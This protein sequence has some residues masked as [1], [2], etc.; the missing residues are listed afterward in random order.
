MIA[1]KEHIREAERIN[2]LYEYA[3]LDT[4]Q[5]EDFDQITQ[6]ASI[7]CD[8]PIN[9]ISLVDKNRQWFKSKIGLEV[10]ETPR[11]YSFCGH[12]IHRENEV[13]EI[14]DALND[15]R[16][17]DNPLVTEEPNI[18]FYAGVPLVSEDGLP[19][20]TVCVIDRKPKKLTST[21]IEG[22]KA[23]SKQLMKLLE[24]RIA[25]RELEHSLS[26]LRD[27]NYQL[28][29]FASLAAHDIKSP[30]N[31]II[32]AAHLLKLEYRDKIDQGGLDILKIVEDSARK[33]TDMVTGILE[34]SKSDKV[35]WE[36][37]STFG[38]N[39]LF[40]DVRTLV[41]DDKHGRISFKHQN[42]TIT[43]NRQAM[44]QI[45]LN[46]VS[47]AIKYNDKKI[48]EIHLSYQSANR[49][50]VFHITDNGPGIPQ[51]RIE[52]LFNLFETGGLKD[53][54]GEHGTGIGLA[55]VKK[56]VD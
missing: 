37:V 31:N 5:E 15:S 41:F 25:H 26:I 8:T 48:P 42:E 13:F 33:M 36:S 24:L 1:P 43:A 17:E 16:F 47:N 3:I 53:R 54:F 23:L 28:E 12:A 56:L 22:L 19:L 52:Q 4:E 10:S 45:I 55:T 2:K 11:D 44:I 40:D 51:D 9:L 39:E 34:Y 27:K 6:L 32:G 18:R 49:E 7:I 20:G 50:S 21:Q 14:Q 35:L 29:R 46:L 30:L 38:V